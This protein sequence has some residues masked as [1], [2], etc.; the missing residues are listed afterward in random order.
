MKF[1]IRSAGASIAALL[2]ACLA[3][4]A[5]SGNESAARLFTALRNGELETVRAIAGRSVAIN[6]TN[7]SGETPLMYAALYSNAET[8]KLLLNRGADPNA[9]SATG[10]TALMLATGDAEK[11]RLLLAKGALVDARSATGRTALLI[12]ASRSGA[13][14][15]VK[16]LLAHQ[17]DPNA[18]DDL[19]GIP[20]I[21]AG[22][23][24]STP[25]IEAAKIRDGKALKYLLDA[26]AKVDTKDNSGADAL[27]AAA[28]NGNTENVEALLACGAKVD[29][30]VTVNQFTPLM[31]AAWRQDPRLAKILIDAGADVNAVD[32]RGDTA[33]MWSAYS[34][35]ADPETT[36]VLLKAGADVHARNRGGESAMTWA[37][38]RG[39]TAI[40]RLLLNN[41]AKDEP[42]T[43]PVHAAKSEALATQQSV[44]KAIARLQ[45][46]GPSF[47]KVSGC[48]SCH[49][50]SIPQMATSMARRAGIAVDQNVADRTQKQVAGVLKPA[51]L[52][53][54]EMSDVVP[55]MAGGAGYILLGMAGEGYAADEFTDAAVF[56]LAAKQFP[57]GSWRPWAPRP[58]MEFSAVSAT[59]LSIRA[60][61]AYAPPGSRAE[62][63]K[64]IAAGR[65]FLRNATPRTTEEKAMR[66]LGLQSSEATAKEID[67]ATRELIAAQ[68]ADGGWAQLDTLASDAYATGQALYVLRI[69]GGVT[70]QDPVYRRGVAYLLGAQEADG[71]WHVASRS[72]PFQPYNESG[73]PHGKDQWISAAG[74]G[75]AS[76]AL[77]LDSSK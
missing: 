11:V 49:N 25:L 2:C 43:Q 3:Y 48:I 47:F 34:D 62:F 36:R 76:M 20:L 19:Q 69:A 50:Q 75:W 23:G 13:G 28:L 24:G 54:I 53:L 29:A 37:R 46:S 5:S 66:L 32:A 71:T 31:F 64:R 22:G 45:E 26:G 70:N 56:N 12:A 68:R 74:T 8:V 38:Q 27:A 7:A 58:P 44:A 41:G 15:V 65:E 59:A 52:P 10:T 21:P 30:R 14:E 67:A 39:E 17:A 6:A 51:K 1:V 18:K 73:F 4:P 42:T 61:K 35:Y 60:L 72:F 77:M 9:K 63:E 57:D 40:V 16:M 33:L 55:D